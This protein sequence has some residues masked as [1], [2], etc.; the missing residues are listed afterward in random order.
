MLL[1]E[2]KSLLNQ[3]TNIVCILL[4]VVDSVTD[5]QVAVPQQIHNWQYLAIVGHQGLSNG[6][7]GA[8]EKLDLLQGLHNDISLLCLKGI[9]DRDDELRQNRKDLILAADDELIATAI[10]QELRGI[11]LF[12]QTL[13]EDRQVVVVVEHFD[14]DLPLDFTHSSLEVYDYWHIVAIIEHLKLR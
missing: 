4:R 1:H 8:H 2:L 13:E 14:L 6:I 3:V 10:S 11:F 9:L 7:R 12:S 5:V